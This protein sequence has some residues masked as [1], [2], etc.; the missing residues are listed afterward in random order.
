MFFPF[1][2]IFIVFIIFLRIK[3]K[4]SDKEE[5]LK[6]ERFW[7]RETQANQV[8]KQD[9]SQLPYIQV[10]IDE[11]EMP[12]INDQN[13]EELKNTLYQLSTQKIV[14]LSQFTNT[15]LKLKYGA[16]NLSTLSEYDANY[17]EL[18]RTLN[19]LGHFL[20][21]A[22]YVKEAQKILEYGI[23]CGT[24][25]RTHYILLANIYHD[26]CQSE[27]I[28]A[29]IKEANKINSLLK[30]SILAYLKNSTII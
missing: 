14:N 27:K 24:D 29:L 3:I 22:N 20:Y 13:F 21:Q 18:I 23:S 30:D 17:T 1:L 9:V 28:N 4:L 6:T 25:I 26:T 5:A 16:A 12:D 10:P 8:R 2:T 7:N 15:D 19:K 11:F